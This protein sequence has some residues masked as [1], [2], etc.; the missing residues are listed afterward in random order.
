MQTILSQFVH[1]N[2]FK[3]CVS[4]KGFFSFHSQDHHEPVAVQSMKIVV[5]NQNSNYNEINQLKLCL[6]N[7]TEYYQVKNISSAQDETSIAS[8][9]FSKDFFKTFLLQGMYSSQ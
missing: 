7:D 5:S 6:E 2:Y 4:D 3:N 1:P 8:I 9:L